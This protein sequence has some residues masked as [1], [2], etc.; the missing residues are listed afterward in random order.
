MYNNRILKPKH[1]NGFHLYSFY[2]LYIYKCN[3]L[4]RAF[5]AVG[6]KVKK[7][8]LFLLIHIIF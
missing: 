5:S 2:Y 4:T 1:L 7:S 3:L 6:Y 8:P